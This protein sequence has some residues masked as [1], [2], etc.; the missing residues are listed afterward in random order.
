M[1]TLAILSGVLLLAGCISV[2]GPVKDGSQSQQGGDQSPGMES[3]SGTVRIGNRAPGELFTAVE[4][5]LG[6]KALPIKVRDAETGILVSAGDDAEIAG[7][8][9]DCSETG[10]EQNL[11]ASYRIVVQVWS[12]GEGSNV[13]VQV[14]GVA[15]LTTA[16]GN[17][18]VKPTQ[19]TSTS[20][21]EKDLL[22]MLRK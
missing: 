6:Q 10:Q 3:S 13:S 11:Q 20:I 1:R 9:L 12:A 2:Y 7:T 15:G 8:Y 19:C 17:D 5:F 16:D 4:N 14:T 22:E 18:K 21:F